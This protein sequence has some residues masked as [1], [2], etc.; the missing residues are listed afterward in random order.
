VES[1]FLAETAVLVHLQ[2]VGCVLLVFHCV[3]ITLFAFGARKCNLYSFTVSSHVRHL[4]LI[5]I[6]SAAQVYQAT[7]AAAQAS[8]CVTLSFRAQKKNPPAEVE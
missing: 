2:P 8:L 7:K 3:V 6:F 1:V 5:G 4:H